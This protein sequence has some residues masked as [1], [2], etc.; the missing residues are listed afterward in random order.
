M[1]D[2][3]NLNNSDINASVQSSN[4]TEITSEELRNIEVN[5]ELNSEMLEQLKAIK[6]HLKVVTGL[7]VEPDNE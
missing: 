4:A 7:N 2:S 3:Q 6:E 1:G 5:T